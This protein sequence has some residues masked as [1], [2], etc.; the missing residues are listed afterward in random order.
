MRAALALEMY[1][2]CSYLLD[3]LSFFSVQVLTVSDG[4]F[5][6]TD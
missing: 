4:F 2:S 3:T 6:P 5:F 1:S